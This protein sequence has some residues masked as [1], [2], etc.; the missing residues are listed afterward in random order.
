MAAPL[1]TDKNMCLSLQKCAGNGKAWLNK[2]NDFMVFIDAWRWTFGS[3]GRNLFCPK[4]ETI[5]MHKQAWK[6]KEICE[7]VVCP[8][9]IMWVLWGN[10]NAVICLIHLFVFWIVGDGI[11]YVIRKIRKKPFRRYYAGAVAILFTIGWLSVGW[12]QAHHVWEKDYTIKTDK[13]V[14]TIRIALLS[15]SHTGTT[16]HAEGFAKHMKEIEAQNPDV[17][18]VAGDFVDDDTTK[19]DMIGCCKALGETKT[20]YGVYYVFGNHDKGYYG[21]AY[22]GY[23]GQDLVDELEANGVIVLQDER[24]L[25]DDRFY[26]IGRQDRSEEA[27]F[28]DKA[29]TGRASMEE[30]TADLDPTKFSIVMDHQPDDYDNQEKAGVDLVVSG[31]THGG[32]LW[33]LMDI[34]RIPG[35]GPDDCVYGFEKRGDTNFIVTSGISDW[36]IKFKTGCRSEYVIID[37]STR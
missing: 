35:L 6:W 28:G 8:T 18:L 20:K 36:A 13:E 7:F 14:G 37:V 23:S 11:F 31:H 10:I 29:A 26:I 22:R 25:I 27:S 3:G 16:F 24:V 17:V 15:D 5:R 33:P 21:D 2:V 9:A 30:L 12:Y 34:E 4:T 1:S 19:E 32:Q